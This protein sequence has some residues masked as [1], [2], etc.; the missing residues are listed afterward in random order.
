MLRTF[1]TYLSHKWYQVA[2][3]TSINTLAVAAQNV[4]MIEF[5]EDICAWSV[6]G[7]NYSSS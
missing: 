5:R 1:D 2:R 4:N 3:S 6:K 7:T